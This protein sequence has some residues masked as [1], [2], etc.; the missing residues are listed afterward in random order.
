[1]YDIQMALW[2]CMLYSSHYSLYLNDC[3]CDFMIVE[4][5]PRPGRVEGEAHCDE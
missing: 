2:I 1:M 3:V 4:L 5:F